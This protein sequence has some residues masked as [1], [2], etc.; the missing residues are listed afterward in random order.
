[1]KDRNLRHLAVDYCHH[2]ANLEGI[3]PHHFLDSQHVERQVRVAAAR[4]A[5]P[6]VIQTMRE[7]IPSPS[8]A[9][10]RHLSWLEQGNTVVVVSGQQVGLFLGPAFAFYKAAGVVRFAQH[11]QKHWGVR[12]VP[13]FWLQNEDH[14]IEEI[15]S[16][17]LPSKEGPVVASLPVAEGVSR[18]PVR[19][20]RL[21]SAIAD[22]LDVVKNTLDGYRHGDEVFD[23]LQRHYAGS[24][25]YSEA[26]AG[27]LGEWF[28]DEGLL[29]LDARHPLVASASGQMMAEAI[30]D[31]AAISQCLLDQ[32][33]RLVSLGYSPAV[34]VRPGSPLCF[35]HPDGA[36]GPR[37]RLDV[38]GGDRFTLVGDPKQRS[39][40]TAELLEKI[41]VDPRLVSTSA[42][43]RPLLQDSLL[44]TAVTLGGPS[45]LAYLAQCVPLYARLGV[46]MP[47]VCP[48]PSFR[49]LTSRAVSLMRRIGIS[50]AALS[51]PWQEMV[52]QRMAEID[53]GGAKPEVVDE[54]LSQSLADVVQ[55]LYLASVPLGSMMDSALKKTEYSLQLA[56]RRFSERYRTAFITRDQLTTDRWAKLQAELYP[57]NTPQ[58][59][60]YGVITYAAD[61][62]MMQ[63]KRQVL[64]SIEPFGYGT[65]E[66]VC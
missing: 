40:T 48:R 41:E 62:G 18:A 22:A 46:P 12:A 42:L 60:V 1:M 27:A 2:H 11:I 30:G 49:V 14:D 24:A 50:A 23:F 65:R 56:I 63:L 28:A 10:L 47:I 29:L 57:K 5:A 25:T 59:R 4:T 53:G 20:Q 36:L 51:L 32:S 44:P 3:F 52:A 31:A 45:E 21:G 9:A 61:V 64:D 55:Q 38:D 7:T 35:V 19:E 8:E 15:R 26:F 17:T 6:E 39:L 16:A 37:Y 33:E 13:V 54:M 58:E 66:I 43:L 34:Y